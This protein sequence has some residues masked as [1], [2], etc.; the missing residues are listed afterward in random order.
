[1]LAQTQSPTKPPVKP[2]AAYELGI[3]YHFRVVLTPVDDADGWQERCE[4]ISLDSDRFCNVCAEVR[5]RFPGYAIA[6]S[7][8]VNLP[9]PNEC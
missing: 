3:L 9:E 6:E 8:E 7:W 5:R 1:M 2:I 4:L